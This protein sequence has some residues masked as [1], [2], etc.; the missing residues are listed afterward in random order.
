M[1]QPRRGTGAERTIRSMFDDAGVR[2]WLHVAELHRPSAQVV[3]DPDEQLPLGSVYKVPLMVAFCRLADA[4][5]IDPCRRLTLEAADRVAGPT[6]VSVL[7]DPVTMSLRDLVTL[8]MTISDNTAAAAV[9]R[10]VGP[11]VVDAVCRDLGM[12]DTRIHG[13]V[14]STF[15]RLVAE[16]GAQ[17][18]DAALARVADNDTVVPAGVYDPAFKASSTPADMARLLRAIWTGEAASDDRCAFMRD[19]MRR[20]PWTHRLASGFPYD[21]VTVYGKTGTF[22]SLRHEAGVV[23]LADGSTYTAVVFTQAARAD[24][25][26]PRADAVIGAAARVAVEE[27]R[28]NQGT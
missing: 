4:G 20:Q 24:S 3:I 11:D 25:R 23:E 9:L 1:R 21:D 7:H 26:L 12:P 28:G 16:T 2:G 8:M 5:R 27:L 17:S 22:G 15:S 19:V 13:G 14:V 18:L 6:G 10:A